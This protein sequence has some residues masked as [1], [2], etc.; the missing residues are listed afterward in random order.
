MRFYHPR[1][2]A[3]LKADVPILLAQHHAAGSIGFHP[4]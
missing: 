3:L 2:V 4:F 1:A